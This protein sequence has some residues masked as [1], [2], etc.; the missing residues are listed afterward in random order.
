[1]KIATRIQLIALMATCFLM[2]FGIL[3]YLGLTMQKSV[4]DDAFHSMK[5]M[6]TNTFQQGTSPG[7]A[8]SRG[9]EL[10]TAYERLST[11]S[12]MIVLALVVVFIASV[13]IILGLGRL[14]VKAVLAPVH[15]IMDAV[16]GIKKGDLT[17]RIDV[18]SR[19]EI[20]ELAQHF[21]DSIKDLSA[22]IMKFA[23]GGIVVSNTADMLDNTAADM[24]KGV[25]NSVMQVNSVATASE[26][27]SKTSS[28]IAQNC[29][30]AAKSSEM[31]TASVEAGD[32]IIG[33][34]VKAMDRIRAIVNT[35]EKM[36]KDLGGR[37]DQIGDIIS[38]I[39]DIADQTNL[40]ALNAA[41][42]AARAGEHGRGFAVVADEVRKLSEKTTE[43]TKQV[44]STIQ[45]MQ[46][47]TRQAVV[48]MGE[49]VH[50]VETGA[51]EARK[52][53]DAFR[54]ILKQI[55]AVTTQVGQIA[56]AAEEQTATTEEIAQNI[57]RISTVMEDTARHVEGNARAASEMADLAI[58]MQKDIGRFK[59]STPEDAK[60]MV[61]K[62][63]AFLKERGK[64]RALEEF[65]NP[66]SRFL[67]GE[68]FIFAQDF[69]GVILAHRDQSIIGKN[70]YDARDVN[71][72]SIGKAMIE[73]AK[74]EGSGWHE[75]SYMN[76]Y[77]KEILPK[78]TYLRRADGFFIAC[79]VF[80]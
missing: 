10:Q 33:E 31:V 59:L 24:M 74:S 63:Y 22:T 46:M 76:P 29:V 27:M 4:M 49:G 36:L 8:P 80:K 48:S 52:S 13:L 64:E 9:E 26:E 38:L 57:Q 15:G 69:N 34:T 47:E 1:M 58:Q 39:N 53:S 32:A 70:L 41:I 35:S 78:V 72:K 14:A 65:N 28:E 51:R 12:E 6:G 25:E 20:G 79:G 60:E 11:R 43:A 30:S 44:G 18:N 61:E 42:E 66:R 75:Y 68:L 73:K 71:G 45:A 56:T 55:G 77:T 7:A 17:R 50:E 23:N 54:E 37:S 5:Q 21:N 62:A 67:N 40:L 3:C 2:I 16:E 19:N